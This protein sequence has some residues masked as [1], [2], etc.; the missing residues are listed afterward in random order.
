LSID[1]PASAPELRRALDREVERR[2]GTFG[3]VERRGASPVSD[4]PTELR[5]DT[6][7]DPAR[8]GQ[9]VVKGYASVFNRW[10]LD[11]GGFREKIAPGAFDRVLSEDPAVIL[12]WDHD[13]SR[14]LGSTRAHDPE[15]LELRV[16]PNGLRFFS[17]VVATSYATDL[18]TLMEAGIVQQASFA[19]TVANDEWVE[20]NGQVTRTITEVADLFDVTITGR[21]AYQQTV[22]SLVRE[23][24]YAFGKESGRLLEVEDEADVDVALVAGVEEVSP[25]RSA[26]GSHQEGDRDA[27][28]RQ[29]RDRL[30]AQKTD[31][32][33]G[34]LP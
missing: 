15:S 31:F 26:G 1:T 8:D 30:E 32:Q 33:K 3:G 4:L 25:S 34:R 13:T 19:F 2:F 18:R 28:L 11:L 9:M 7:G 16:D 20:K 29:M 22:S 14:V 10:S 5:I 6:S 12:A 17:R 21:G 24:A 27:V 23:R